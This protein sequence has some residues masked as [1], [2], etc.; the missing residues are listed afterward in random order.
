GG[1]RR[2]SRAGEEPSFA[3]LAGASVGAGEPAAGRYDDAIR[4]LRE[5]R[6]TAERFGYAWLAAWSRAQLGTVA[7]L[8]GRLDQARELLDEALN[9]SLA[10][11]VSRNVALCLAAFA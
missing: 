10:I 2:R 4:H 9:R 8:Q 7:V 1:G 3:A 6:D 5:M 11:R